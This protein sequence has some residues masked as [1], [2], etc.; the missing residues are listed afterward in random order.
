METITSG[1]DEARADLTAL[2]AHGICM[3]EVTSQLETEGVLAFADS[4]EALYTAVDEKR[5]AFL[6]QDRG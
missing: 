6:G 2:E 5:A 4:F 3:A 1:V